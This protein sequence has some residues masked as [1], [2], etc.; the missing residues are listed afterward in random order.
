MIESQADLNN[1]KHEVYEHS[2][3]LHVI[4]VEDKTVHPVLSVPSILFIKDLHTDKTYYFSANH[5][6]SIPSGV[7]IGDKIGRAHV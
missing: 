2:L 5:P 4:S 7:A 6:D 1:F 3:F